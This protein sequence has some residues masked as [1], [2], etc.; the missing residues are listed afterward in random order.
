[1]V[2]DPKLIRVFLVLAEELSFSRAA[3][4]LNVAQPWI[5]ERIRRLEEHAGVRLFHRTSRTVE[6][7]AEGHAFLPKAKSII[8]TIQQAEASLRALRGAGASQISLGSFNYYNHYPE[9]RILVDRFMKLSPEV[10]LDIHWGSA[11]EIFPPLLSGETDLVFSSVNSVEHETLLES[12]PVC[13]RTGLVM[14]P[15]EHPF[16]RRESIGLEELAGCRIAVSPGYV[17]RFGRKGA[18][19]PL[20]D[21][22]ARLVA[23]PEARRAT[24]EHYARV[25]RI[26]CVR[27]LPTMPPNREVGDMVLTP[28]RDNPLTTTTGLWRRRGSRSPS[29]LAFWRN[30]IFLH[31]LI[32]SGDA[33]PMYSAIKDEIERPMAELA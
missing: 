27:W 20:L 29:A 12:T 6:L 23:A 18:L 8:E 28:I 13:T 11:D 25:M 4:Q 19:G 9:R 26:M 32:A 33:E 24:I 17:S 2:L 21:V 10:N 22:G 5:S 7:S 15:Q 31:R 14:T 30:A 16:A 1:V 3:V